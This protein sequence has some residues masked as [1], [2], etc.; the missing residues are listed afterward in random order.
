MKSPKNFLIILGNSGRMKTYFLAAIVEWAMINFSSF[1]YFRE[2]DL[3]DKVKESFETEK[4]SQ[5]K[6]LSYLIDHELLMIDDVASQ[7]PTQWQ[8]DMFFDLVDKRY[9]SG[10]PT[11]F[12]SNLDKSDFI[13]NY[14]RRVISRF[15]DKDNTVI[16]VTGDD[17]RTTQYNQENNINLEEKIEVK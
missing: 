1:R 10:L 17:L 4:G 7:A 14:E 12:T 3:W 2:L 6:K 8:K 9:S 16:D 13:Q 15:F 11:I 5:S